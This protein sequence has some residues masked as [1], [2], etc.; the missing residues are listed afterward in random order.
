MTE[1]DDRRPCGCPD[2]D[3]HLADCG[4]LTGPGMSRDEWDPYGD[5]DR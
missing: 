2:G 4:I 1:S 5:E 3:P